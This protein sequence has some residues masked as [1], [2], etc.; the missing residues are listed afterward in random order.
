MVQLTQLINFC[1]ELLLVATFSDYAPN[2]LQIEG[3]ARV[4]KIVTGVTASQALIDAAVAADADL[5]LVHHGFFWK[6]ESA[7][8]TGIKRRRIGKLIENNVS[9]VAYHLPLDAHPELGNNAQLAQLLGL[10]IEGRFGRDE[11]DLI[12]M[13]GSLQKPLS[14]TEFAEHISNALGR[15]VLHLP[16]DAE[17]IEKVAWCSGAAQSYIESTQPLGVQAFISGEV[18]EQTTHFVRESGIHYYAAGHHATERYGVKALGEL[19]AQRFHI[20]H[21]FIDIDNPI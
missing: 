20:V 17:P 13:F 12:G 11:R 1:D 9:L 5:L 2:G 16:G 8:I 10:K 6:G 4:N 7:C 19:L 21:E 3:A 18:S 14:G 15:Q